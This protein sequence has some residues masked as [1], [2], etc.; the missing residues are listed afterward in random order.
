[1]DLR[2][3][4]RS[5]REA[6]RNIGSARN[7]A[8]RKS[9][10]DRSATVR[11]RRV[12]RSRARR[13]FGQVGVIVVGR[14]TGKNDSGVGRT[15]LGEDAETDTPGAAGSERIVQA[16]PVKNTKSGV[17]AGASSPR[18]RGLHERKDSKAPG[19]AKS[20]KSGGSMAS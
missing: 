7:D 9:A 6:D 18:G 10:D 4:S 8:D 14:G 12:A 11:S 19:K 15:A 13:R 16:C 20:G 5:Q 1:M 3:N 17:L 2:D